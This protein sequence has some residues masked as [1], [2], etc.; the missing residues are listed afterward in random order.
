MRAIVT[1]RER[2]T[3]VHAPPVEEN[4]AGAT[5][6]AITAF[7]GA[8]EVEALAQ[9]VEQGDAGIFERDRVVNA[10]DG[11]ADGQAHTNLPEDAGKAPPGPKA[12][13]TARANGCCLTAALR[14]V[15]PEC[16]AITGR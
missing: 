16:R 2:Q 4:G 15:P 9:Q 5:L 12:T 13:A 6:A 10:V 11:E 3:G 7:L 8:G 1:D 14:R